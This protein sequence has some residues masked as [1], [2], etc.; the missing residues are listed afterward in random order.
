MPPTPVHLDCRCF[1]D[2]QSTYTLIV[3]P[4]VRAGVEPSPQSITVTQILKYIEIL[5]FKCSTCTKEDIK[6][7]YSRG[8]A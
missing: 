2:L 5:D 8:P 7:S 6:K 4:H 3:T 1:L